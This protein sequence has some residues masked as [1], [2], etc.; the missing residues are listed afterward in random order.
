MLQF[1]GSSLAKFFFV[2][3]L[4]VVLGMVIKVSSSNDKMRINGREL[5]FLG[6]DLLSAGFL[7]VFVEL[8]NSIQN[9]ITV[10]NGSMVGFNTGLLT[11]LLL[12][13][14]SLLLM[15]LWIRKLGYQNTRFPWVQHKLWLGIIIPD[16]WGCALLF[17]ILKLLE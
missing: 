6:P 17:G 12:C 5:F 11:A 16:L 3:I 8:C 13:I 4:T 9:N 1:L 7:L 2:P 10:A 15:P 14:V